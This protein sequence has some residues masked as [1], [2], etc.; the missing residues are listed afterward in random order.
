[1]RRAGMPGDIERL[2]LGHTQRTVTDLY[3]T[4]LQQDRVW[5][6]EWCERAALGFS[7][8]GLHWAANRDVFSLARAA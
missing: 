4:G 2:W 8:G 7:F 5:P 1:M 3:A 6:W